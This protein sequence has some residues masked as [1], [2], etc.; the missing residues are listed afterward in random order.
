M[1]SAV[2]DFILYSDTSRIGTGGTLCQMINGK[3]RLLGYHS[4]LLPG[5]ALNY[6]V[7]E[8]EYVGLENNI[9]A[10][11]N[12]LK[13]VHFKALVDHSALVEKKKVPRLSNDIFHFMSLATTLVV[14]SWL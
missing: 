1:P 7:S 13:S 4:K 11:R 6:T 5:A 8:L 2:G 12:I 10:F 9:K 14:P 3:E